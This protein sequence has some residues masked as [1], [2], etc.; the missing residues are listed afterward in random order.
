MAKS[1]AES[2]DYGE[3][4]EI[5]NASKKSIDLKGLIFRYKSVSV[6]ITS[7]QST[8]PLAPGSYDVFGRSDDKSQNGGVPVDWAWGAS[9][10]LSNSGGDVA[11]LAGATVIDTVTYDAGGGWPYVTTGKS[12][13]LHTTWLD[14]T[15]NDAPTAWC[16]ASDLP[17]QPKF[18]PLPLYGTPGGPSKCAVN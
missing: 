9:I 3:Y 5:Y 6:T 18:G 11:L 14:A 12:F 16:L 10:G 13:Q 17:D 4:V 7:S 1:V 8:M 15:S 2:P